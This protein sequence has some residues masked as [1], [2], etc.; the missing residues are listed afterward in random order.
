MAAVAASSQMEEC[1]G[2]PRLSPAGLAQLF[3]D[4]VRR[5][6]GLSAE[7]QNFVRVLVDNDRLIVC[8]RSATFSSS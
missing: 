5:K 7:Q 1:I 3:L 8:P 2:N 6:I 4:D